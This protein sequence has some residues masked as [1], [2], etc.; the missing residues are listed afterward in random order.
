[1]LFEGAVEAPVTPEHFYAFVTNPAKIISI[2]PDVEESKVLDPAHFTIRSKVGMS[3]IKGAVSMKFEIAEK[4]KDEF[5]RM[6]GRGQGVQSTVD[7][8]MAI[9]LEGSGKSTKASW[10]AEAKVG[11]LLASVGSR[12]IGSVAEKYVKEITETL[13]Q[14]VS[15]SR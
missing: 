11:G 4:R 6:V 14:K 8:T 5:V 9:T 7:L 12:L 2:L 10:S 3:Y 13:R 15:A 1:M